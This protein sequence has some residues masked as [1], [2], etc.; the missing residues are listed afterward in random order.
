MSQHSK[1]CCNKTISELRIAHQAKIEGL[2][3]NHQAEVE[4]LYGL[5][6]MEIERKG[7]FCKAENVRVLLELQASYNKKLPGLYQEQYKLGY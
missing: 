7:S 1:E 4:R 3:R 6:L 2:H 5:H